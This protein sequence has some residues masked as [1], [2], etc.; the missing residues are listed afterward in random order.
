M[1]IYLL[2]VSKTVSYR[3]LLLLLSVG[4]FPTGSV[5]ENRAVCLQVSRFRSGE[6]LGQWVL[7]NRHYF[8]LGF[9]HSV[10]ET[11]VVDYYRIINESQLTIIQT[12][13]RFEHHGA[14]L[15]SNQNEGQ[16]WTH[17]SGYFW[18]AMQRDIPQLIVRTDKNYHNRL[19][20]GE[21]FGKPLT[22][23]AVDLNQWDDDALWIQPLL[24]QST[25]PKTTE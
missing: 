2:M 20:I 5:A 25:T 1:R 18:L 16:N 6:V 9:V 19:Y 11:P 21:I 17:H 14:G 4:L 8:A 24:C 13:E 7:D 23:H 22:A 3:F 12:G 15:P 10:S